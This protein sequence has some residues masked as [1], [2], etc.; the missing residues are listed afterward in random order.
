MTPF[1]ARFNS[2]VFVAI[3]T[4]TFA[5]T[6]CNFI[7]NPANSDEV[8]RCKNTTECEQEKFFF[9]VLNTNRVDAACS[10][11]GGG[12]SMTISW[13]KPTPR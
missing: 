13:S 9:E 2:Q 8:I 5:G 11:P 3:F 6:G 12:G 4:A 7:L 1:R 10:A